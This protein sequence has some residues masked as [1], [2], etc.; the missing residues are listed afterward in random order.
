MADKQIQLQNKAKTDNLFPKVRIQDVDNLSTTLDG[1]VHK[2]GTETITGAKT[3]SAD[4]TFNGKVKGSNLETTGSF[5]FYYTTTKVGEM[6]AETNADICMDGV[7]GDLTFTGF[8]S[9]NLGDANSGQVE[10][11][12]DCYV[13]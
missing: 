13:D 3:F 11:F 9:I 8:N 6:Y 12:N 4:T 2:A 10:I 1:V 7:G 5:S